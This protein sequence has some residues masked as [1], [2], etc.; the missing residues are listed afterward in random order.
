MLFI[1][2]P[3]SAGVSSAIIA[4]AAFRLMGNARAG[5]PAG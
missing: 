5:R 2:G 4:V 3:D 1:G